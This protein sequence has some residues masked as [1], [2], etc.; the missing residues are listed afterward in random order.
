[1]I[2]LDQT[3]KLATQAHD[4]QWR[5][6]KLFTDKRYK[7]YHG[8]TLTMDAIGTTFSPHKNDKCEIKKDNEGC[9]YLLEPYITSTS[10]N[11]NDGYRRRENYS[12]VT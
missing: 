10:S 6:P 3:I 12:S 8:L 5:K 11:G 4:K 2:T 9:F 1:M 7:K